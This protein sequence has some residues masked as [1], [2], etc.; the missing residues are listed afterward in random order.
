V[1]KLTRGEEVQSLC[2]ERITRAQP[3]AISPSEQ[4][5]KDRQRAERE[6]EQRERIGGFWLGHGL[7]AFFF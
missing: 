3:P 5:G 7:E 4:R 6:R 1:D 2:F